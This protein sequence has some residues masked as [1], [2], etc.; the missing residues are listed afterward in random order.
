MVSTSA[1]TICLFLTITTY[2]I[3]EELRNLPGLN[4]MG[5]SFDTFAYQLIFLVGVNEEMAVNYPDWCKVSPHPTV[6]WITP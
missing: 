4:V 3:F 6:I 2:L 5:L 1:S